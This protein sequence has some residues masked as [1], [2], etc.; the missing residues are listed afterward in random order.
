MSEHK[1]YTCNKRPEWRGTDDDWNIERNNGPVITEQSYVDMK[2]RIAAMEEEARELLVYRRGIYDF[3]SWFDPSDDA[4][5]PQ[6]PTRAR[7]FDPFTD[8]IEIMRGISDRARNKAKLQEVVKEVEKEEK[9]D[10]EAS[11]RSD[12]SSEKVET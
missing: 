8:G 6:D 4:E 3:P 1:L 11:Q 7:G 10:V 2:S 9:S 5:I 12:G